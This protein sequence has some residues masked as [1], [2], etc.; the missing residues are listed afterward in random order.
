[1]A[2]LLHVLGETRKERIGE[3]TRNK[4]QDKKEVSDQEGLTRSLDT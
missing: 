2:H 3:I 1:M 4:R